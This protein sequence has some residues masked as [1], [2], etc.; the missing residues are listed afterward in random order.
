MVI[1]L[2]VKNTPD[3]ITPANTPSARLCVATTTATVVSMTTELCHGCLPILGIEFQLKVPIDTMIMIATS[4]GIGTWP[5]RSP[6]SASRIS[7]DRPA[8]KVDSRPRPPLVTLMTDWPIIA[9]PPMPPKKAATI[10][11]MP[12]PPLSRRLLLPVCVM[13]STIC[14]VSSD[15]SR[16]TAAMVAE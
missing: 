2:W 15:S 16:P 12:W 1:T 8:V 14:A 7:S 11:A 5:T 10:L 4:A 6:S 3:R 13:S 9:Q